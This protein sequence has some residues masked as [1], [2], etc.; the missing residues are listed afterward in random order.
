[1]IENDIDNINSTFENHHNL[2]FIDSGIDNYETLISGVENSEL[3]LLDS[4]KNGIE[5]ITEIL[6]NYAEVDS[7]HI[8]SHGQ[9]GSLQLGSTNLN[10]GNLNSYADDLAIWSESLT[11]KGDILLYGC[12]VGA[13]SVGFEFVNSLS[14]LTNADI[15]A[16]N[17][18]TGNSQ[19]GG[20]WDLE[21]TIGKIEAD[22]AIDTATRDNFN[23][24][25][26]T[27]IDFDD[28]TDVS[29][30]QFNGNATQAGSLLRLTPAENDQN[31][32]AFFEQAIEVDTNTSFETQ[33]QFQLSGGTT[34]ADGFT[35]MLQ[36]SILGA[37][38]L[39]GNGG[40]LGYRNVVESLAIE[41]D[42][43]ENSFD[44]DGNHI[45]VLQDGN[46]NDPLTTITAPFDLNSG[47]A[48]N[49]WIDY[50]GE[51][52][53]LEVFLAETLV[54]PETASLSL[55]IDLASI[56]GSEAFLGFSAGTGGLA[57]THDILNWEFDTNSS[58]VDETIIDF[59]DE[60]IIDFDDFADV[61]QLQLNGNATQAGSLLRLTPAENSQN[62][63]A[64]FEQ[65]IEVDTNTSFETQFQFQLSEGTTGADGFTFMLQN[66]I[67]GA[68]ALG[69][70]G[71]SLGYRNV[72][73][74]LAIEFDTFENGFDTDGNQIS[75]LQ[76]GNVNE[77]LTTITAPFD[78]N[79]GT[80]LNAWIDYDGESDLLEVFLADTLLKPETASLSL[81]I[82]LASIVGSEA[83]LGFSAGTG[84]L[85]NT[86]DILNWE[87]ATNSS[88]VQPGVIQP[89]VIG[90]ETSIYNVNE[91]DGTVDVRILRTQGSDGIVSLDY[92]TF[93]GEASL[94]EDYIAASGTITFGDG[95]T[96]KTVTIPILDDE[97]V[98]GQEEF[99]FTI[100]NLVG[101]ATLLAPR[102]A[103]IYIADNEAPIINFDDFSD[104]SQLELNEN[105]TQVGNLLRLT[106]AENDQNGSALFKQA[107]EVDTNTSFESQFQFQLSGGTT[108]ADGFTFMLLN[109]FLGL[110]TLGIGARFL[111]YGEIPD[112]LAIE[113]D[114]HQNSFDPDN[115]HIS[116]LQDGNF[117]EPLATITAP[118]DL[119]SGSALNAW[120]DY[121]GE[122]DLLEVF[123]ADTLL[124]PETALLSLNI[125]LASIVGSEA[126]IGFSAATGGSANAHDIINWEFAT[127]SSLRTLPPSDPIYDVI[128][129][130]IISGLSQPTAIEWTPDGETLFIAEKGGVIK[131][132]QD[133]E[134][135]TTSF[136]DLSA[137]VNGIRDRGLL[138]I[139][140]HPDFFNG[141]PY[142]YALY[143]YDPPEVFENTGLAGEDGVG[144]RASRLTRITAD[145][146]TN[147]TTAVPGSEEVILGKNST[148]ENFNGFVNSTNDF[149]EPPAGILADG[150][151]LED[152][153]A[154]DSETHGVGSVEFGLDGALYVSNGDG[155]SYNQVD[156]RTVRVQDIDNLSGKILRI[157]PITGDGLSDNPFF[158]GDPKANRSKVYQYGLRN[159]IRIAVHP[160]TGQVYVGDVGWTTWE[161]INTGAPGV[162]FGW[163]YYEGGNGA[164]LQTRD[165]EDLPEAQAFYTSGESATPSILGLNHVSGINAI[166]LGDFYTG[167]VYPE[168]YQG[169][170]F[171]NDLG[172]GIVSNVSFDELGNVT[173]VDTFTTGAQIV[174]QIKEG[175]D[176]SLYYVDLNDGIVGRWSVA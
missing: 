97:L 12:D 44:T 143:I 103:L 31:G 134:L 160:E 70:N 30:L 8:I 157:D 117:D 112:S 162:N 109:S 96:I 67:L 100:D 38:A 113:F 23:S 153:L 27:I 64:F 72:A 102:T 34:G 139:A 41:F 128:P 123:L 60:T 105:A 126:L 29:Q 173:A 56:V 37:D 16:S 15:A 87:F 90:L 53:L 130:T 111:G 71:G 13:E 5:Q 108:G 120:I 170:L 24:V 136:I 45:S 54:K 174:V 146:S 40:S 149:D 32:S 28:F 85:A 137:Q 132:V 148:W 104:T 155:T 121:D 165:Y 48:L 26:R 22:L 163:P 156:P 145:P 93:D 159:P 74:S 11:E 138:D 17:D 115:N 124:K 129:E 79:S 88:F 154:V 43:F 82:D 63:S 33:F 68:N 89:G 36:N 164:S 14:Q 172:Q 49:A 73:E 167:N 10:A 98:E 39:G 95:E 122:S 21:V 127:N 110:N 19:L 140:V 62:G 78:L 65:A 3:I 57:N 144:N 151:N 1:M 168:E 152:F 61:S 133:G 92:D 141:S 147:F 76:D 66:S 131:V 58:F 47:S 80:A 52:D 59:V 51:S 166:I 176:D 55:N 18:L 107:L 9:A 142:V 106:P 35:F 119:N 4:T 6:N 135:Q 2:L 84:G 116:V 169:D 69:G 75:V 158:N 81:N 99:R 83:F 114:T 125:D 150:T 50:D 77:P 175:P 101:D 118:F 171:F 86:H 91:E 7:I 94:G 42:T 25:L 161:E 46:V 20:D